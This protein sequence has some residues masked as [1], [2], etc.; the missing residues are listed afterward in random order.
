M[1]KNTFLSYTVYL[2]SRG[3]AYAAVVYA[4]LPDTLYWMIYHNLSSSLES[5][6]SFARIVDIWKHRSSQDLGLQLILLS[7]FSLS[8]LVVI[9]RASPKHPIYRGRS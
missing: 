9:I 5:F 6:T 1:E 3:M 2:T 7:K 8:E 4:S